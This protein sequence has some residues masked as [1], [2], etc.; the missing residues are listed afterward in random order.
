[1]SNQHREKIERAFKNGKI[2]CLVATPTLAQGINLPARRVIIRDYKRWN[3]A[4]GRNIP[5]SVMEIKQ[6]MG[7]AGRPKYDSRGESW[8][9]AKS[10]Q[11]VNF[12]AEKYIS[13]Q[14]ENVISKL[15]NPNAKKAEED[16][17]L[18]THVL[19]MIS[20]GDLRDRDALGRFFQKTFLSTQLSTEDLA[21]RIDDSINWLVNNSMITREGESEVVKERILQ[22]VEE[23]IEENWEDLRPSWVNSAASIP[24]LDISEQSIVEKKIY[25]PREGPA[26]LVY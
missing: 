6:M 7:R 21:S 9:L 3:T 22:H 12:L 17:Y 16:P 8:I 4:A 26:I 10:E 18:L 11:E 1:M 5:I 25:S 20:T 24:G 15:S 14:P 19:S 23:D 13:G 2:N